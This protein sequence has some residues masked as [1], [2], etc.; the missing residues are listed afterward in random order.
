MKQTTH[1]RQWNKQL[2]NGNQTNNSQ[3]AMKQTTHKR[4]SNKQLT[5]HTQCV[6]R[7]L[8]D[9][10]SP[11]RLTREGIA[12]ILWRHCLREAGTTGRVMGPDG[13]G[14]RGTRGGETACAAEWKPVMYVATGAARV[15]GGG[16]HWQRKERS[17][18]KRRKD[19][20]LTVKGSSFPK[21]GVS[22]F[23]GPFRW[24]KP[25]KSAVSYTL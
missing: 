8:D 22:L 12:V 10:V 13:S 3:T 23:N 21:R 11:L 14:G 16:F 20:V 9:T 6:R 4:Q 5:S 1:K 2:T 19:W 7:L 17:G 15:R 24:Y 18:G 25:Q